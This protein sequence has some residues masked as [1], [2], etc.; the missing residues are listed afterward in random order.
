MAHALWRP[1]RC[2]LPSKARSFLVWAS[3]RQCR[4]ILSLR[5]CGKDPLALLPRH[6]LWHRGFGRLRSQ[7]GTRDGPS[8]KGNQLAAMA[9]PDGHP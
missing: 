5:G 7:G 4:G 3:F 2:A 1:L 8:A 6:A 9:E